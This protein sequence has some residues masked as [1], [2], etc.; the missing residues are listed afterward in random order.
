M[1]TSLYSVN[2]ETPV[3]DAA[4]KILMN[5]IGSVL[6]I[7][8]DDQLEGILISADFVR[9][10]AKNQPKDKTSV[11]TYTTSEVITMTPHDTIQDAAGLMLKHGIH[12]LPVVDKTEGVIGIATTADISNYLSHSQSMDL[13]EL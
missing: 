8:E 3:E 6:V 13:A 5:V 2:G 10:I 4:K 7:D 1:S 12:H 11:S 9:I